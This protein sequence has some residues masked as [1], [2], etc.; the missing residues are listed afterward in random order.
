[1]KV[2]QD[3]GFGD[4]GFGYGVTASGTYLLVAEKPPKT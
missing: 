4:C 1:L 2:T 3:A